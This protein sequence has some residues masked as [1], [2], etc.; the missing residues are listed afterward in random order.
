MGV[1]NS[2]SAACCWGL[3]VA[4]SSLPGLLPLLLLLLTVII[5]LFLFLFLLLLH[6]L[7]LLFLWFLLR[8][9]DGVVMGTEM[10]ERPLL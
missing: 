7:H 9:G 1:S 10:L 3:A 8:W 4:P 5:S 6:L 2:S